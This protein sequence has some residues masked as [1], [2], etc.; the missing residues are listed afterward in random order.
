LK[1]DHFFRVDHKAVI[2]A[3]QGLM[4]QGVNR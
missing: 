1:V 4:N 3:I 2:E